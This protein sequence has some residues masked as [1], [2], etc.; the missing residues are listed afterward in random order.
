MLYN[1]LVAGFVVGVFGVFCLFWGFVGILVLCG[2]GII[3][4]LGS[5]VVCGKLVVY[6]Q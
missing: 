3:Q 2:V 6:L 5:F 4:V 1:R